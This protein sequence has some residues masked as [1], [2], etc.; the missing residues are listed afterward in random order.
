MMMAPTAL[1]SGVMPRLSFDQMSIGSVLPAGQ[2][3]RRLPPLPMGHVVPKNSN[4]S[5]AMGCSRIHMVICSS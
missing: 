5:A 4:F 3:K 1:I 2:S